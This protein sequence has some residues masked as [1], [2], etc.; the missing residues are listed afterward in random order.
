M[1]KTYQQKGC[2]VETDSENQ[3]FTF[4]YGEMQGG[5]F[6]IADTEAYEKIIEMLEAG[7]DIA[8]GKPVKGR[9]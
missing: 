5:H 3:T 2:T 6:T 4:Y 7:I 8:S 1:K 9:R